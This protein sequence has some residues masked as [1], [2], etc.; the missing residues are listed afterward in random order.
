MRVKT[1]LVADIGGSNCRFALASAGRLVD[2][3]LWQCANT[4][5]ATFEA[6]LAAYLS[7]RETPEHACIAAAGPVQNGSVKLTNHAWTISARA[8][9]DTKVTLL[10][11]LQAM[12]HAL[13]PLGP[14]DQRKLVVNL[15]T[16]LNAAVLHVVNGKGFVPESEA[17]HMRLPAL[18]T[19]RYRDALQHCIKQ[20]G[21]D[22][23]EA[24]LSGTALP[25]LH[26][27]LTGE[28]KT[29]P[30]ISASWPEPTRSLLLSL[31]G[32]Y[33]GD[34]ALMHL[35]YGGIWLAGSLGRA[36]ASELASKPFQTSF[37]ARGPYSNLME[38]FSFSTLADEAAA[39][40]GAALYLQGHAASA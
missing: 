34:L 26:K 24:A 35:P 14:R 10:N 39:L 4:G 17:G 12:G 25:H 29:A 5:F 28:S 38:G 7:E 8:L 37:K 22:A 32:H 9:P 21:S 31:L 36:L 13:A 2:G 27:A 20:Y 15:G 19:A 40:T 18:E 23:Y 33:L 6:A 1:D 16:G 11:D 30:E 3:S